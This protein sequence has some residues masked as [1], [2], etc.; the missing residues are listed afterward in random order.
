[1]IQHGALLS[2]GTDGNGNS[3]AL[4][5]VSPATDTSI[6]D[7]LVD[8][9]LLV[10]QSFSD[11]AAGV[12]ITTA[13]VTSTETAVTVELGGVSCIRGNP[14]LSL[15]PSQSQSVQ[16]GTTVIY[17]VS[18][19][20][21]DSSA[22]AKSTFGLLASVPVG[23]TAAAA[24]SSLTVSPGAT[25]STT[26]QVTSPAATADGAYTVSVSGTN[27]GAT[28]YTGSNSTPY[29][30]A[31]GAGLSVAITTNQASYAPGQTVSSTAIVTSGGNPVANATVTFT[32]TK[33]N[34]AVVS[35]TATT[36]STGAA[37]Y[38]LRIGRRDPI[39]VYRVGA[40]RNNGGTSVTATTSFMVQ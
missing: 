17:T 37:V 32:V 4:I 40:E 10:G 35:G 3:G 1:M 20:N 27:T 5:D 23:W 39:G 9:P 19:T 26:L 7:W 31:A 29:V 21:S 12:T 8:A 30:V 25:A 16:A 33:S 2:I 11:P 34:G 6:W 18:V 15:S 36:G 22:C 28:G 38:R 14:T 24:N 13:W